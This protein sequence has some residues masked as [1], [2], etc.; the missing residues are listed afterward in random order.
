MAK[1]V[2]PL[3]IIVS[4][5]RIGLDHNLYGEH[6]YIGRAPETDARFVS[7]SRG[8]SQGLMYGYGSLA[9]MY[10]T[11]NILCREETYPLLEDLVMDVVDV[12]NSLGCFWISALSPATPKP[13]GKDEIIELTVS[14]EFLEKI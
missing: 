10:S 3:E 11:V 6:V 9:Y 5:L 1:R 8:Q 7:V 2:S 4:A 13:G 14:G 12:V